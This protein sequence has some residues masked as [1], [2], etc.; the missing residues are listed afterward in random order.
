M[1]TTNRRSRN[2]LPRSQVVSETN[3]HAWQAAPCRKS[4]GAFGRRSAHSGSDEQRRAS[5]SAR[6]MILV[7]G[8]GSA[9]DT[10]PPRVPSASGT[11]V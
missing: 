3:R 5:R 6:S 1:G 9:S 2:L 7:S 10:R 4:A 8:S 11:A